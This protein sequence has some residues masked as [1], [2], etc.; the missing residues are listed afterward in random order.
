MSDISEPQDLE[1][2]HV[3]GW[4]TLTKLFDEH[5]VPHVVLVKWG[6]LRV[7]WKLQ[8]HEIVFSRHLKLY[9]IGLQFLG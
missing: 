3:S 1:K 8:F 7:A 6:W 4:F 2:A 5:V 9:T